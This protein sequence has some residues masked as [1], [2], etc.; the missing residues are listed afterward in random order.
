M[1]D[2]SLKRSNSALLIVALYLIL[3]GILFAALM[4]TPGVSLDTAWP[5][6]FVVFG[7]TLFLPAFIW[8]SSRGGL[9]ALFVPG[10]MIVALGLLFQYSTLTGDWAAWI[11]AWL[12][13]P[14]SFG[15][16]LLLAGKVGGWSRGV[17]TFGLG[18][19]VLSAVAYGLFAALMGEMF[20]KALGAGLVVLSGVLIF[21][22]AFRKP[23][24]VPEDTLPD[25]DPVPPAEVPGIS[26]GEEV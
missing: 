26:G 8:P 9:A 13:V 15:L 2:G 24:Q 22:A 20:M 5:I 1:E 23:A 16:G 11:Y 18:I 21:A 25:E 4:L 12:L 7:I 19:F 14:A 3:M 10:T 6:I 17:A